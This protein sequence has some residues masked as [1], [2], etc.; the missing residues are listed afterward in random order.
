MANHAADGD[1]LFQKGKDALSAP[2]VPL[3][4]KYFHEAA[5]VCS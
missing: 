1:V 5:E 4:K 3:A 2:D